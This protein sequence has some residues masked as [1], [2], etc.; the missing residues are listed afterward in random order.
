MF[1]AVSEFQRFRAGLLHNVI[2]T[3]AARVP[4]R[5]NRAHE[6]QVGGA[7]LARKSDGTGR[8]RELQFES[9]RSA[10]L[11]LPLLPNRPAAPPVRQNGGLGGRRNRSGL[12]VRSRPDP[13]AQDQKAVKFGDAFKKKPRSPRPK[14]GR[15]VFS[16]SPP[17]VVFLCPFH[18]SLSPKSPDIS[19][20]ET[21]PP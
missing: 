12:A 9:R 13:E 17:G 21:V 14:T 6:S 18:R 2:P 16:T 15:Q 5:N 20:N 11:I 10:R 8:N 1:E 3:D 7:M 4:A 19:R